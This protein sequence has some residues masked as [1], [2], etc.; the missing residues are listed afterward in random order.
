[1]RVKPSGK[2]RLA[3]RARNWNHEIPLFHGGFSWC[4][5]WDFNPGCSCAAMFSTV[6]E[7]L[8]LLQ[9]QDAANSLKSG[10]SMS[11]SLAMVCTQSLQRI[12]SCLNRLSQPIGQVR[13][14]LRLVQACFTHRALHG[15]FQSGCYGVVI[16]TS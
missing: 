10:V 1:M 7:F 5:G 15:C 11:L 8:E 14:L 13:R 2:I 3:A 9:R 4:F 16:Q 12:N 6:L